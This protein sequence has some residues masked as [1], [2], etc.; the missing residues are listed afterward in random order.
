[1]DVQAMLAELDGLFARRQTDRVEPFLLDQLGQAMAEGDGAAVLTVINELVG[2]YRSVG[3]HD[4][5]MLF[6][7]KGLALMRSMGIGGV[8][9]GTALVNA[10]TACRAGGELDEALADYR[11]A[12]ALYRA[13]LPDGDWRLAGFYNNFGL[14]HR[15]MGAY[16][17]ARRCF[18]AALQ[19]L[20]AH[21]DAHMERANTHA[22]RAGVAMKQAAQMRKRDVP[23]TELQAMIDEALSYSAAA[24][25]EFECYCPEDHHF[26]TALAAHAD[27]L[28]LAGRPEEAI[29]LYE[30][31]LAIRG[32]NPLSGGA[33]RV[34]W[35]KLSEAHAAA[36]RPDAMKGLNLARADFVENGLPMLRRQFPEILGQLAAGLVG[37]GSEC[38]GFDDETSIDHD[39]GVGFCIWVPRTVYAQAGEALQRAYAAL[40]DAFRGVRRKDTA[41]GRTGVIVLEDFLERWTGSPDGLP[42]WLEVE[43]YR[44][45]TA[46]NGEVFFDPSGQLTAA[47]QR[48]ARGYP[49]EVFRRR[50]AQKLMEAAQSGQ[51]NYGRMMSRGDFTGARL[52]LNRF[53]ERALEVLYLLEGRYAPYYKW[54][55]RGMSAHPLAVAVAELLALEDQRGAWRD[56]DATQHFGEINR[57]DRCCALIEEFAGGVVERLHELGLTQGG[58]RY[59]EEQA[60]E[61]MRKDTERNGQSDEQR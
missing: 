34:L 20:E 11:E 45:A 54:L 38:F 44:L 7:R 28:V 13:G 61:I 59:L 36:G 23:A 25:S 4:R 8:D 16:S 60:W 22:N 37:E 56:W 41:N 43:E 42:N 14:L 10:A 48:L 50:L 5:S 57:R 21:P 58:G 27:A 12:E 55:W 6:S 3:M 53:A 24:V 29:P 17:E 1:M 47:R 2:F 35:G 39:F 32:G 30:R 40:P 52:A 26:D 31:A 46:V 51:Y 9:Y 49:P 19:V 15:E 33:Y 18:A